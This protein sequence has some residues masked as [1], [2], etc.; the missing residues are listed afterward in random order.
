[1][2][3][4]IL[5][6]ALSLLVLCVPGFA[7]DQ[8]PSSN[9][10]NLT[11]SPETTR[12]TKPVRENGTVDYTAALNNALKGDV[13]PE[14]NAA[15]L[16]V[17]AIGPNPDG[18]EYE[19]HVRLC[20]A[21]GVKPL[22]AD[23]PGL[24]TF[25]KEDYGFEPP[26]E[27]GE[28]ED[29]NEIQDRAMDRPW[30]KE[31]LPNAALWVELNETALNLVSEAVLKPGYFRPII[32]DEEHEDLLVY[33]LLPDVQASREI[34]RC[35]VGRAMLHLG[36]KN[37]QAAADD[38][39]TLHRFARKIA[40]G[41]TL[42]ENLVGYALEGIAFQADNR[43]IQQ[44]DLPLDVCQK[45][46]QQLSEIES[47]PNLAKS[48]DLGERYLALQIL[49]QIAITRMDA[50]T[51]ESLTSEASQGQLLEEL[52]QHSN[53]DWNL[54]FREVNSAYDQ[55]VQ[56]LNESSREDRIENLKTHYESLNLGEINP[57][58]LRMLKSR[59]ADRITKEQ[60]TE[61]FVR[62]FLGM[63]L[64]AIDSCSRAEARTLTYYELSLLGLQ[65]R[66][67]QLKTGSYPAK[68]PE[69]TFDAFS[70]QPYQYRVDE[71][72]FTLYSVGENG[73]DDGGLGYHNDED[74]ETD[75]LT[76]TSRAE[77]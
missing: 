22:P 4:Q 28:F 66:E 64:P 20:E 62:A 10:A 45:Y 42:V 55:V 5:F 34:G 57:N 73:R 71:E 68:L 77:K 33:A 31:E 7:D 65:L 14:N 35:L 47:F 36:E 25:G 2:Q 70:G 8:K 41:A 63:L 69:Q 48:L 60:I 27:G 39:L 74:Q 76:V 11:V 17:K 16:I 38:L 54:V 13:T 29:L 61:A 43:L 52:S 30:Q 15:V 24:V 37:Y 19:F 75:D 9:T 18:M 1:M 12:A 26:A 3:K 50:E 40:Q 49:Q 58:L 59:R 67:I 46:R 56:I 6:V 72:E 23:A 21:M 51:L 53:L 32:S 44:P